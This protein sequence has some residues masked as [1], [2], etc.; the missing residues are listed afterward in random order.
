MGAIPESLFESELF[1]HLKGSFTDAREN[2]PGKFEIA[3]KGTLFLDEIGN[4]SYNLQS[5]L[6]TV[7]ESRMITRIGSNQPVPVDIRLIC[8]T[9]R[10][11]EK[12]VKDGL[13]REDLLYRINTIQIEL[14]PLRERGNDIIEM[15]EF[16]L[17]KFTSKYDKPDLRINNPAFDKLLRYSWPGN[18][19]ELQNT[20]EKAVILCDTSIIKPE[21]FYLHPLQQITEIEN[22]GTIAE[23][24]EK[25]IN[26][27]IEKN[28][29]NLTAAAE[30]LGITRQTLYNKFRKNK[31]N[32]E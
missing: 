11:L 31:K 18:I 30:L 22:L 2:R 8:A 21:D 12:M 10:N 29:G 17:R 1:G 25:L 15:A 16:F 24:E 14:T 3:D 19:R 23:M 7:L 4:L 27:A 6:L 5:K 9:N 20:I 28:N 26:I 32:A 13:F